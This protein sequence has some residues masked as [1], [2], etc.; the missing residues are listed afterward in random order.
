MKM[1]KKSKIQVRPNV[2]QVENS[3]LF[4]TLC[5]FVLLAIEISDK[6]Q[7]EANFIQNRFLEEL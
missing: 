7:N 1:S 6:P 5:K 4:E 3:G 2:K